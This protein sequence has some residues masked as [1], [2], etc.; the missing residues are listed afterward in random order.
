MV[1]FPTQKAAHY[2]WSCPLTKMQHS[3]YG[4]VLYPKRNTIPTVIYLNQTQ[5]NTHCLVLYPKRST[6]PMVMSPNQN[7]AQ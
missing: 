3:T 6:I 4:Q 7:A 2:L 5:H 1:M